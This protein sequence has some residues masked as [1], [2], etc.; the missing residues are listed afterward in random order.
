MVFV[1]GGRA[2]EMRHPT[3]GL[4]QISRVHLNAKK[5][6]YVR[7]EKASG[8][9]T[10]PE[11]R[12]CSAGG[13]PSPQRRELRRR[14]GPAPEVAR[15]RRPAA[16]RAATLAKLIRTQLPGVRPYV[17]QRAHGISYY[18]RRA[19]L[20]APANGWQGVD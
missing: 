5:R 4:C 10:A 16:N 17:Q 6:P 15:P 3:G 19:D 9:Q 12:A 8:N 14:G 2:L 20:D 18:V 11:P 13:R 7:D 1:F